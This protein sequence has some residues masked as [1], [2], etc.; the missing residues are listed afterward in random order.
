MDL[1]ADYGESSEFTLFTVTMSRRKKSLLGINIGEGSMALSHSNSM[2]GGKWAIV[3]QAFR[4]MKN[5]KKRDMEGLGRW[6]MLL[7]IE[8]H[9]DKHT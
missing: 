4:A 1:N 5:E 7:L 3:Q 9:Q 8:G 6:K 2:S